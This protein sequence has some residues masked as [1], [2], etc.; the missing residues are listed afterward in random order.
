[1]PWHVVSDSTQCPAG[2]P[3]AVI[4]DSDGSVV[5]CHAT[6]D[7]ADSHLGALYANEPDVQAVRHVDALGNIRPGI[8][9]APPG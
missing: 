2:R 3:Y 6:R 9:D 1:M 8:G 5:G 7:D 4:K